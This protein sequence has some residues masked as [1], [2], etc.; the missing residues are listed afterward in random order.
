MLFKR[1]Y[2]VP[3]HYREYM[4]FLEEYNHSCCACPKAVDEQ[5]YRN[6][7]KTIITIKATYKRI[8]FQAI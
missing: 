4:L 7:F 2:F 6:K 5:A 8:L 3:N 1:N